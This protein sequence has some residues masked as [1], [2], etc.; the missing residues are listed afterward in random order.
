MYNGQRRSWG[1]IVALVV[2]T[3][4]ISSVVTA[5][6]LTGT[7][8]PVWRLPFGQ[9]APGGA[10]EQ[11][12]FELLSEVRD[13]LQVY[14]AYPERVDDEQLEAGAIEGMLQVLED[15][16]TSYFD[17]EAY[18]ELMAEMDETYSGVGIRVQ[19]ADEGYVTVVSPIP[20]SPADKA[21][22][23]PGDRVVAVDGQELSGLTLEEAVTRIKGPTGS[24]VT[25]TVE[26]DKNRFDLNLVRATIQTPTVE[27]AMIAPDIGYVR[28]WE[29]NKGIHARMATAIDDL[30]KQGM[31][32]LVLDLR[33]NPGGLMD[34]AIKIAD[35][36]LPAG[37]IIRYEPRFAE[38]YTYKASGKGLDIPFV[39]LVDQFSASA[40]EIVAGAVKDRGAA[41]LIGEKTH[42]KGII[43][44]ILPLQNGGALKVTSARYLTPNGNDIHGLGITPDVIV[45]TSPDESQQPLAV[46]DPEQNSQMARAVELLRA[47]IARRGQR[48]GTG[49]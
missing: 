37:D 33:Q 49:R 36:L 26:R 3:A 30:R 38:S 9:P 1:G 15:P 17:P 12:P 19:W 18:A 6:A 32:G 40:S 42:G 28:L 31:Q 5:F 47:E 39:V 4:L 24:E 16:Y 41:L 44:S 29:F 13:K 34:E 25:L 22:M 8:P 11:A 45:P 7:V 48:A 14:F 35:Y 2:I 20:G 21:G 46:R 23:R 10:A 43:Q 27:W